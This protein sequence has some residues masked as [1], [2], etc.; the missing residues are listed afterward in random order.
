MP[1]GA[2]YFAGYLSD[3]RVWSRALPA[4]TVADVY[5]THRNES[6]DGLVSY[7][8][9]AE[10]RGKV[11]YDSND[12]NTA[13]LSGNSLWT[14]YAPASALTLVVD[15]EPQDD[16][17]RIDTASV[18]GYGVEQLTVGANQMPGLQ[19]ADA[20]SGELNDL[21]VWGVERTVEQVRED[22]YR[23]LT[24]SEE[25]LA[26]YWTFNAGSGLVAA[27]ATGHG[28]DGARPRPPTRRSGSCRAPRCRMRP[29]RSTT[30]S[31]ASTPSSWRAS[32]ARR[33]SSTTP[34]RG[35]TPTAGSTAS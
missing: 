35:A 20:Y 18:G 8:R 11:A 30:S 32:R 24:G 23:E 26:G 25:H 3:V 19:F 6:A 16:A 1:S 7:W 4:G 15:G 27:D 5:R 17:Q 21:R 34:T 10:G 22:M 13:L 28:N 31:A 9:F 29:R 2:A 33:R 14:V 12:L